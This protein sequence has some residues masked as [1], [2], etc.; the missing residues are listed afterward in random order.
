MTEKRT[1]RP[2]LALILIPLLLVVGMCLC[3]FLWP[4]GATGTISLVRTALDSWFSSW[5]CLVGVGFFLCSLALAFSPIGRIQLGEKQENSPSSFRWGCMVF[6]STMAAD[7]VFYSL[8]EWAL[9]TDDPFIASHGSVQDWAAT[10]PLFH[11]G[12]IAW[13]FYL[14]LAAAFGFMLYVRGRSTRRMSEACRPLL[15]AKVDGA[16]GRVIDLLSIFALLAGTATTFSLS[17]PLLSTAIGQIFGFSTGIATAIVILVAICAVYGLT[18]CLGMDAISRLSSICVW[19]FLALLAYV[20][21]GGGRFIYI[22]ETGITA[23]GNLAQ[24]FIGMSTQLDPLRETSFPQNFT[25]FY[26]AYWMVWC[27]ATPFFIGQISAGRTVR[28]VILGGYAW[29]LAGTW[30]SFIVLGNYGLSLQM[31]DGMD[32][33]GAIAAGE[34]Y[35]DAIITILSTL[36]LPKIALA[37][38][39]LSMVAFYCTTFDA[40]TLI[41]ASY[42]CKSLGP[43]DLPSRKLRMFWAIMLILL[44]IALLFSEGTMNNLQSVSLIAALPI[45]IV[46]ILIAASFVKDSRQYLQET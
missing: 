24:N 45:S 11:W 28:Q 5:Y 23:I 8:C 3:F 43:D 44:P 31:V 27:V 35:S 17:V 38:V 10:F 40:L 22:V 36:P 9:Y 18:V 42:C 16:W 25:M 20:G 14:V 33:S 30:L 13:S 7:I 37:L 6:T 32:I 29:G 21:I 12:P 46:L 1:D 2:D 15:G 39:V 19:L 4:E 41:A 34:S 26:W